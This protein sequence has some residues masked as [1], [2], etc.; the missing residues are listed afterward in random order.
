MIMF[1]SIRVDVA[2]SHFQ[3]LLASLFDH[4]LVSIFLKSSVEVRMLLLLVYVVPLPYTASWLSYAP[5]SS[6]PPVGSVILLSA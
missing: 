3:P 4:V 6:V 2:L 5:V 1:L